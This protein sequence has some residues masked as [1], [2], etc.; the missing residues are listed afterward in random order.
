M[1]KTNKG[2]ILVSSLVFLI[3]HTHLY[4]GELN[5]NHL[6]PESA[7]ETK[8]RNR[9]REMRIDVSIRIQT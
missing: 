2:S 9:R 5:R 7:L 8:R 1:Q 6:L 4:S 3:A